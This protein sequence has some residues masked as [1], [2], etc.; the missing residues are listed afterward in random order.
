MEKIRGVVERIT[1]HNA[2][3]GYSILKMSVI[4]EYMLITVVGNFA[5]ITVGVSLV[6]EGEWIFNSLYSTRLLVFMAH[7]VISS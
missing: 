5:E 4:G 6:M 1:Y 2:E 3:N 7:K